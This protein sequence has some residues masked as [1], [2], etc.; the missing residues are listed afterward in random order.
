[1]FGVIG[2]ENCYYSLPILLFSPSI[3]GILFD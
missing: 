1:M 3:I 2:K